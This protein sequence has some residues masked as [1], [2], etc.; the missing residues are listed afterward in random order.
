[1]DGKQTI[2]DKLNELSL[3]RSKIMKFKKTIGLILITA[4]FTALVKLAIIA[5]I[6]YVVIHFVC[7][8]W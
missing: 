4:I 3:T 5:G 7:K 8:Y 2:E 1:M 6:I